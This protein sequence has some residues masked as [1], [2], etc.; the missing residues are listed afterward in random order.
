M[1]RLVLF[2]IDE[3][4][5]HSSGAGRKALEKALLDEFGT[6]IKFDGITLSGKTDPQ[7]ISE[8]LHAH[9]LSDR[10]C[11]ELLD[12]IFE[13]YLPYL[14]REVKH[15]SEYRLHEGVVELLEALG[16]REHTYIGL[17]TG[18]IE[19]GA[20]I[21]L[22]RFDLNRYFEFGAFGCDSANRMD[23]PAVA[24]KRALEKFGADIAKHEIVIIGDA[25]N[26]VLCAQGYGAKS[27]A[28]ATGRT[29]KETLAELDPH[30]LF[31]S[32]KNTAQV[33]DAIFAD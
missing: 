1:T 19:R 8:V 13:K 20:R 31:D 28:V 24:H 6:P 27:L 14:E 5:I 2:D 29:T 9:G 15:A 17:L 23:L 32:L 18:N 30:Y 16:E 7:I 4:M 21:K 11:D 25:Q 22:R 12:S 33:I 10:Q 3:T 26:D